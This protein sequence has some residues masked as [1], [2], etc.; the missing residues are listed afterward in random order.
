MREPGLEISAEIS[1]SDLQQR[2]SSQKDKAQFDKYIYFIL[3]NAFQLDVVR[4]YLLFLKLTGAFECRGLS[5][6]VGRH[7][8]MCILL[9]WH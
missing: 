3:R 7:L 5:W 2:R 4:S 9:N 6:P 8:L 1:V